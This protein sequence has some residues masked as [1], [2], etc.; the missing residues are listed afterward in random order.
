MEYNPQ[1]GNDFANNCESIMSNINDNHK[2]KS[3]FSY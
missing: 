1:A 3:F 2:N